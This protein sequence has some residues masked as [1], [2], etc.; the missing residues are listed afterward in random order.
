MSMFENYDNL[1]ED[2]IPDNTPYKSSNSFQTLD[3][4][5]PKPLYDKND[6][7]I[8]YTWN[9]GE[10]FTLNLSVNDRLTVS[11][12][13]II[14]NNH[15][16][17]PETYTEA[18]SVGQKAYNVVDAKSWTFVG[19]ASDVYVWIEDDCLIYPT[20][21]NKVIYINRDMT[22]KYVQLNIF[23][24]KWE[25]LLEFKSDIG[26]SQIQLKMDEAITEQLK[27]GTYYSTLKI[28]G[29]DECKLKDKFTI[30]IN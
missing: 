3:N 1:N 4:T 17:K 27:P 5:Y 9:Y 21:G 19:H 15:N 8:G 24:F 11:K 23:N 7:F 16:E 13:S 14:F 6:K 25:P 12:D 18:K 2:Y 29:E 30:I 10:Y 20:D 28:V 22:N 26:Q